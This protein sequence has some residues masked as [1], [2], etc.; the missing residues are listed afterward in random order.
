MSPRIA[1]VSCMRNEGPFILEW[2]AH[3]RACGFGPILV[4]TNDCTDGSDRLL[5][6]LDAMGLLHHTDH[7]PPPGA[8]PQN[9]ATALA[10]ADA[11]VQAADWLLHSD[12][13]EF[14]H[15]DTPQGRIEELIEMLGDDA[16][17]IILLWKLFGSN[18]LQEWRGG[19][20]LPQFTRAQ[21]RPLRRAVHH[22]SLFRPR[23]FAVCANHM[24]RQPLI[25]EVRLV[26]TLGQR[27]DPWAVREPQ[28]SRYGV[29]FRHLTFANACLNHYAVK[30]PD[31]FLMKN[32][33]G[34]GHGTRHANYHL[35]SRL[36][37]RY[38][39]NEAEDRAILRFWPRI[40]AL[41]AEMRADPQVA[42]LEQA[43]RDWHAAR[44]AAVLTPARIAAWTAPA[45]AA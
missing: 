36:H 13:D 3:H 43:C 22:K 8:S 28:K 30:T 39:R 6:R 12:V 21:D 5:A 17:I 20:V 14:V 34:D 19:D 33:R 40:A 24:P 10:M 15:L 35:N 42:Q 26:N 1:L 9:H 29:P 44:R 45:E 25:D 7:R 4:Y 38:D 27:L 41:M 31:L 2:L 23:H 32:D 37:R 16:D 11:R 18:G